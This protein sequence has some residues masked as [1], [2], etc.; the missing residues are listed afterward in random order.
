MRGPHRT[1]A[2]ETRAGAAGRCNVAV[3]RVGL[4]LAG[5]GAQPK[6]GQTLSPLTLALYLLPLPCATPYVVR[7]H[8]A[9][10]SCTMTAVPKLNNYP[11]FLPPDADYG[12]QTVAVPGT[13]KV[14]E[15]GA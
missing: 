9:A 13:E 4:P 15:T 11:I 10:S 12:R 5:P 1:P 3:G 2:H 8:Y 7:L 14:G 6:P